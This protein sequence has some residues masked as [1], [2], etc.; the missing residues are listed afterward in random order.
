[1]VAERGLPA[2]AHEVVELSAQYGQH[3]LAEPA[4]DR[5]PV[6]VEHLQPEGEEVVGDPVAAPAGG[7]IALG[8]R[9]DPLDEP[10]LH[11]PVEH[12]RRFGADG[13]ADLVV[14]GPPR[15]DRAQHE[16]GQVAALGLGREH[17]LALGEQGRAGRAREP[18]EVVLDRCRLVPPAE[19][20]RDAAEQA[21]DERTVGGSQR[22]EHRGRLVRAKRMQ[23]KRQLEAAVER[24]ALLLQCLHRPHRRPADHDLQQRAPARAIPEGPQ[25]AGQLRRRAHQ[26][27]ELVEHQQQRFVRRGGGQ[28]LQRIVPVSVRAGLEVAQRTGRERSRR[29]AQQPQLVRDWARRAGVKDSAAPRDEALQQRRLPDAPATPDER[30]TAW[31]GRPSLECRELVHPV[32]EGVHA[33]HITDWQRR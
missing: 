20:Q 10:Q 7:D 32:D 21:P 2:L 18:A 24:R 33:A 9:D 22:G 17:Q 29:A 15:G 30:E 16:R 3:R 6:A 19:I 1:M 28:R 23:L 5:G 11:Q 4:I 27:R 12:S 26:L 13:V 31:G 8:D 14:L 25:D